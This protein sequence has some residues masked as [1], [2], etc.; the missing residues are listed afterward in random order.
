MSAHI[1][2]YTVDPSSTAWTPGPTSVT[3][4]QTLIVRASG[5]AQ[6]AVAPLYSQVEGSYPGAPQTHVLHQPD[7]SKPNPA[8]PVTNVPGL[9]MA[10][11]AVPSDIVP[12]PLTP[13]DGRGDALVPRWTLE[14]DGVTRVAIFFPSDMSNKTGT[15]GPWDIYFGYNDGAYEDNSGSF[16]VR[17]IVTDIDLQ[18]AP[19]LA[20]PGHLTQDDIDTAAFC[21]ASGILTPGNRLRSVDGRMVADIFAPQKQSAPREF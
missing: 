17:A 8:A 21:S 12:E 13:G 5:Y 3:N 11:L 18:P 14:D 19:L 15:Y 9:S 10:I 20:L 1:S 16:S 7:A 6:W 4:T 2:N